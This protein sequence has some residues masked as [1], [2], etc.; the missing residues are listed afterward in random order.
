VAH[1][2]GLAAIWGSWAGYV[3]QNCLPRFKRFAV[4]VMGVE[5]A[6]TDEEI[7][8]KGIEA[9]EDF[10]RRIGM[11]T[12]LRELGVEATDEDLVTMAHKCAVGVGGEMGSARVLRE[13]D[14]LAIYKASR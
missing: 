14:M 12:N 4:N 10:Y 13:E 1:G 8:L 6:G 3:Y 2:A 5:P 11:P 7:A 9:V